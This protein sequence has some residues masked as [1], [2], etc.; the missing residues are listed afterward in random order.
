M[1]LSLEITAIAGDRR[2]DDG[3]EPEGQGDL[4]RNR[5]SASTS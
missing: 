3:D 4:P 2:D 1:F 5:R